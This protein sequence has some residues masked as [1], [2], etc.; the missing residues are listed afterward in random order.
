MDFQIAQ[1]AADGF[2]C[3][4]HPVRDGERVLHFSHEGEQGIVCLRRAC[5]QPFIEADAKLDAL[6][7]HA[8]DRHLEVAGAAEA[9]ATA[10]AGEA[11]EDWDQHDRSVALTHAR[12]CEAEKLRDAHALASDASL[13]PH[14]REAAKLRAVHARFVRLRDAHH[15]RARSPGFHAACAWLE[16]VR[17][18]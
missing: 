4:G 16:H 14:L 17:T 6:L 13:E 15:A 2:G 10:A 3:C 1:A 11:R 5:S 12:A 7:L 8:P 18:A 9:R